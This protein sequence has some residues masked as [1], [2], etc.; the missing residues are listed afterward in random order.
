MV[1]IDSFKGKKHLI[2]IVL[3]IPEGSYDDPAM[4]DGFIGEL[5]TLLDPW[6][7]KMERYTIDIDK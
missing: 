7:V 2:D 1:R 5:R 4:Q 3:E 6:F